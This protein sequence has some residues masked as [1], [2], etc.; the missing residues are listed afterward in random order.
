M[1]CS[2]DEEV[3]RVPCAPYGIATTNKAPVFSWEDCW[4]D[5]WGVCPEPRLL[6]RY[7]LEEEYEE[8][9]TWDEGGFRPALC[10]GG[11]LDFVRYSS[12]SHIRGFHRFERVR[13]DVFRQI[14]PDVDLWDVHYCEYSWYYGTDAPEKY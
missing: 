5:E 8:I 2:R 11:Y 13:A 3:L 10:P 6:S 12:P 1:S 7:E 9:F 4:E 14:L